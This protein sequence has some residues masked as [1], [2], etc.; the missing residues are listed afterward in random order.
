MDLPSIA[1][2]AERPYVSTGHLPEAE[3]VQTL[4]SDAHRR[5][6]SNADSPNSQICPA[7]VCPALARAPSDLLGACVVG[8]SESVYAAGDTGHEFPIT[9]ESKTRTSSGGSARST[10]TPLTLLAPY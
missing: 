4:A 6:K 8:T 5:F 10:P 1:E 2:Q 7:Q 9:S 3:T